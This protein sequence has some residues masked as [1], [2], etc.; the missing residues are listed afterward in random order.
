MYVNC[1]FVILDDNRAVA[2]LDNAVDLFENGNA[3][4]VFYFDIVE[5]DGQPCFVLHA[6]LGNHD[7]AYYV[8]RVN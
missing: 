3:T 7:Y 6:T 2:Y 8:V 4:D 1:N 5:I